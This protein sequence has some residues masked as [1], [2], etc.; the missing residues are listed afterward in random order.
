MIAPELTQ[1]DIVRLATERFGV[2][3][4]GL[5][6]TTQP[7]AI[8]RRYVRRMEEQMKHPFLLV[9]RDLAW[10]QAWDTI[11]EVGERRIPDEHN[12]PFMEELLAQVGQFA[13]A[14]PVALID[15]QD[16]DKAVLTLGD[17]TVVQVKVTVLKEGD[18]R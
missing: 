9:V 3:Y 18:P 6:W 12:H 5:V 7:D 15:W 2:D 11:F 14:Y 4:P 16:H 13:S 1:D 8:R 10:K 17:G